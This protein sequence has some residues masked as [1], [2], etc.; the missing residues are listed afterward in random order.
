L[1]ASCLFLRPN[2]TF[3]LL[4]FVSHLLPVN[5]SFSFLRVCAAAGVFGHMD[6]HARVHR[7][8]Q[9]LQHAF[10]AA[11]ADGAAGTI[12]VRVDGAPAVVDFETGVRPWFFSRFLACIFFL[13]A[14]KCGRLLRAKFRNCVAVIAFSSCV[15]ADCACRTRAAAAARTDNGRR[16]ACDD[17][18]HSASHDA[19]SA[20][21]VRPEI[22]FQRSG[23]GGG[24]GR[25]R[26]RIVTRG[27]RK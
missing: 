19:T 24:S 8:A 18:P 2:L 14:S 17:V 9:L 10:G 21:F 26:M 22:R 4:M 27:Y 13:S 25:R 12:T 6:D 11:A 1:A 20:D 5:A 16:H 7:A 23:R 15:C 3:F